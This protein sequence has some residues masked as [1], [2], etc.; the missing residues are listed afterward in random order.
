MQKVNTKF[1]NYKPGGPEEMFLDQRE[2]EVAPGEVL[3]KIKALGI[4]RA[5]TLQRQ[6]KIK[7][8]RPVEGFIGLEASG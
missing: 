2:L 3:M 5:E 4:N 6:G 7:I 1:V 8:N